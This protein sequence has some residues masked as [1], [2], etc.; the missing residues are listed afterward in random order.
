[1]PDALASMSESLSDILLNES[2]PRVRQL[3]RS[4][5]TRIEVNR[6]G[7]II[8][9]A[10]PLTIDSVGCYGKRPWSNANHTPPFQAV[11]RLATV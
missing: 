5:I 11:F 6:Q 9:Y 1:V 10:F 7:G 8:Y 4:F 3:L 2:P